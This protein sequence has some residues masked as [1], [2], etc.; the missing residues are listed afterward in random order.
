MK[1]QVKHPSLNVIQT[2]ESDAV[3]KWV[4][5]GWQR[6]DDPATARKSTKKEK[7]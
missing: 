6:I 1:V 2:V 4:D 3:K 5:A 7:K